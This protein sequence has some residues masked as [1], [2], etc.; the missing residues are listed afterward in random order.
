MLESLPISPQPNAGF[1]RT[2]KGVNGS[3]QDADSFLSVFDEVAVRRNA[4]GCSKG[5][6]EEKGGGK[7]NCKK[8]CEAPKDSNL[9]SQSEEGVSEG[10]KP[11]KETQDLEAETSADTL[12]PILEN[13]DDLQQATPGSW[14]GPLSGDPVSKDNETPETLE[15]EIIPLGTPKSSPGGNQQNPTMDNEIQVVLPLTD[16]ETGR[17]ESA[18]WQ[19]ISPEGKPTIESLT[20]EDATDKSFA[21]AA[22]KLPGTKSQPADVKSIL[23][24][25]GETGSDSKA[26]KGIENSNSATVKASRL[27]GI[28]DVAKEKGPLNSSRNLESPWAESSK[29]PGK[30]SYGTTLSDEVDTSKK[31][32]KSG[33]SSEASSLSPKATDKI[34]PG[35]VG[36]RKAS[37]FL[38][39]HGHKGDESLGKNRTVSKES[40]EIKAVAGNVKNAGDN[41]SVLKNS[42]SPSDLRPVMEKIPV[43]VKRVEK[44]DQNQKDSS[45]KTNVTSDRIGNAGETET[46]TSKSG[47][48]H[49]EGQGAAEKRNGF[50]GKDFHGTLE[51]LEITKGEDIAPVSKARYGSNNGNNPVGPEIEK[52]TQRS[53]GGKE[54]L[55]AVVRTAA[56]LLKNGRQ[57]ARMALHPESLGHL[58]IRISTENHQVTVRVMADTVAAKELIEHNLHQ[59]KADFQNQGMEITK[60]D[61]SLSQDSARNGAGQN[62][63]FASN[64]SRDKSG[65]K[66]E[67]PR[68]GENT[69]QTALDA[70]KARHNEAVDFFA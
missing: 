33:F 68:Q 14:I 50:Q 45:G 18:G 27:D 40:T 53:S 10:E 43:E 54:N 39:P 31:Q 66:K 61:V 42:A 29:K 1:S 5:V 67:D 48:D 49:R 60:F 30:F 56:F 17:S 47:L 32:E 35:A 59:L 36:E 20:G 15:G 64:R 24:S 70:N 11:D 28:A 3:Q 23:K 57:E 46:Q 52:E 65:S 6:A 8:D 13:P 37:A 25:D 44:N 63:S 34:K 9:S 38:P 21:D 7:A 62:P 2:P 19:N 12:L 55:G 41:P 69:E 16:T 4:D 22:A 58:K 26:E 51:K